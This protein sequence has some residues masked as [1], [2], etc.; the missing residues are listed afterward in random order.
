MTQTANRPKTPTHH[1]KR[2]GLH[3]SR[4]RRYLKTYWPYLPITL[5][6]GIGLFIGNYNPQ[7]KN[8][9]L[10]YATR[11]NITGL[12]RATNV[13]RTAKNRQTLKLN[14]QLNA[15]AQAKANDMAAKDYWSHTTPDGKEPWTFIQASGY[16]YQKAGENLAY[17]FNS[18]E[19][20]IAGWMNSASHRENL[21]DDSYTEVGFG[22]ANARNFNRSGPETIVVSM[23]GTPADGTTVNTAQSTPQAANVIPVT[24]LRPLAKEPQ[25]LGITHIQTL[26]KGQLPWVTFAIGIMIGSVVVAI[27]LRHGL[28]FKKLLIEG[29]EFVIHHPWADIALVAIVMIGYVLIQ[30]AGNIK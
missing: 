14:N 28:A 8:G 20:T 7:T 2:S 15:A 18:S 9:V 13:E 12:L 1:R 11:M 27:L 25:T 3:H 16:G 30:T 17:G 21:L 5:I 6:V 19:D 26:T 24:S 29:E 4:S 22:F 23:Y 10:A